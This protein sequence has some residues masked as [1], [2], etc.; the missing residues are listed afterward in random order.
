MIQLRKVKLYRASFIYYKNGTVIDYSM[1]GSV[2]VLD[3]VSGYPV[4]LELTIGEQ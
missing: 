3:M 4:V 2:K 1:S